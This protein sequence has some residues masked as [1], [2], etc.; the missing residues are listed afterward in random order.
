M[1]LSQKIAAALE[2]RPD[3]GAPP[4]DLAVEDGPHRLTLHL[5]ASGPVGL[6]FDAL[7][8]ATAAW[9]EWSP[10][11]LRAWGDALARRVSYLMEP[12]VVQEH[13]TIGGTVALRSHAPTVRVERRAFYEVRLGRHGTLHLARVS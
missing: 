4:C 1:S 11:A 10:E 9:P 3:A 5:T 13:D 6:A 8:F 7:E 2:E 12:L